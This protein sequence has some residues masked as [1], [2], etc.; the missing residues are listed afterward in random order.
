MILERKSYPTAK[1]SNTNNIL[2]SLQYLKQF[3]QKTFVKCC[4]FHKIDVELDIIQIK[5]NVDMIQIKL[6]V[7]MILI[8]FELRYDSN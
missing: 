8:N 7:D 6:N 2:T 3:I 4:D 5:L 1:Y